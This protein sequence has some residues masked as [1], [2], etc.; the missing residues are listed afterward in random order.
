MPQIAQFKSLVCAAVAGGALLGSVLMGVAPASA[1]ETKLLTASQEATVR[2]TMNGANVSADVQDRLIAKLNAGQ[3]LDSQTDATPVSTKSESLREGGTRSV[4]VFAD[5]SQRWVESDAVAPASTGRPGG[6]T[7]LGLN[8]SKTGCKSSGGWYNNCKIGIS[9][10]VSNAGFY[11]DY[12]TNKI[13]DVRGAY[14]NN[15]VGDASCSAKL[16]RATA[17]SAGPAWAELTFKAGI[18]PIGNVASGAF[19]LRVSGSSASVYG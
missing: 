11:L 12:T 13:R 10:F 1:S 3:P 17:S 16:R 15:S 18:G 9:D 7:T 6:V 4:E 2:A 19:G 5:G 8:P 14:C